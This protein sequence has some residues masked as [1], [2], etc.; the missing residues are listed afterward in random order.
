MSRDL[1]ASWCPTCPKPAQNPGVGAVVQLQAWYR[2][3]MAA[4][5]TNTAMS[6]AIEFTI[7]P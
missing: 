2:D 3:P 5:V 7:L 4:G 1:N 6:D